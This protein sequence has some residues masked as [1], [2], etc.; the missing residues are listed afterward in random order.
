MKTRK[1]L[2]QF[3]LFH[4]KHISVSRL[5]LCQ[6]KY[7]QYEPVATISTEMHL[8]WANISPETHIIWANYNY[9]NWYMHKLSQLQRFQLKHT[10][11][12]LITTLSSKTC[13]SWVKVFS[14]KVH[15]VWTDCNYFT[16][17]CIVLTES[18]YF[19][20]NGLKYACDVR[21]KLS[22]LKLFQRIGHSWLNWTI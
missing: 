12:E 2:S 16:K 9:F 18:K 11:F 1:N 5:Q 14:R 20:W 21:T 4:L 3:Q 17:M 13:T 6:L 22:E 7:I 8:G 15:I 19:N 10:L